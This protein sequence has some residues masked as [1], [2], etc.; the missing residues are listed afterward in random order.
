MPYISQD[1]RLFL[2]TE[3]RELR[4]KMQ[5]LNASDSGVDKPGLVAGDLNYIAFFLAKGYLEAKGLSYN[6]ISDAIK[7]LTGSAHEVERRI[8]D[9][10]EDKAIENNGDI[11]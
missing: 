5:R 10:Y 7:A 6:N 9:P 3:L 8:L 2:E 1:R 11:N 4:L